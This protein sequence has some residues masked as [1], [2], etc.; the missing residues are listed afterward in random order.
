MFKIHILSQTYWIKISRQP[1]ESALYN[2]G[3][4]SP[5]YNLKSKVLVFS[6]FKLKEKIIY[7]LNGRIAI[8]QKST[9]VLS[10]QLDEWS[11]SYPPML[12][13]T[14]IKSKSQASLRCLQTSSNRQPLSWLLTPD[15]FVC[16]IILNKWHQTVYK[17]CIWL[18]LLNILLL[19]FIYVV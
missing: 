15:N 13:M 5:F 6:F 11:Q 17:F 16:L 9:K 12:T 8:I 14:H 10:E 4:L 18:L 3:H 2:P 19:W 1:V 7:L